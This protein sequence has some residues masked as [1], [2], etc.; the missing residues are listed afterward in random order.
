VNSLPDLSSTKA[1]LR[2]HPKE[3]E[4]RN[5]EDGPAPAGCSEDLLIPLQAARAEANRILLAE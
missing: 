4:S 1:R 3:I 2:Q 5:D